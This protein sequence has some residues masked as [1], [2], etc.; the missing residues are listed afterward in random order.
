M[1]ESV[2]PHISLDGMGE[3]HV[4]TNQMTGCRC[5]M[6]HMKIKYAIFLV[7]CVLFIGAVSAED[8]WVAS[9]SSTVTNPV[10]VYVL[11]TDISPDPIP[12]GI[13]GQTM[14]NPLKISEIPP[15]SPNNKVT[16]GI[17]ILTLKAAGKKDATTT[18]NVTSGGTGQL[19]LTLEDAEP[20]TGT[21]K[22]ESSPSNANLK[23]KM[24][25]LPDST[26]FTWG[27][28]HELTLTPGC[29][30]ISLT[31]DGYYPMWNETFVVGGDVN[32]VPMEMT[33]IPTT[34][35]QT[36]STF[37]LNSPEDPSAKLMVN[38]IDKGLTP[39]TLEM[40]PGIYNYTLSKDNYE[41]ASGQFTIVAGVTNPLLN[42]KLNPV[43]PK[44]GVYLDTK[45]ES[46]SISIGC[47]TSSNKTLAL[48]YFSYFA[49]DTGRNKFTVVYS[50]P[51]FKDNSLY[52]DLNGWF[53][54]GGPY[55]AQVV[56]MEPLGIQITTPVN[57]SVLP[58]DG[59]SNIYYNQKK[60]YRFVPEFGYHLTDLSY[61][62]KSQGIS[63][64][65]NQEIQWT[66]P[67]PVIVNHTISATYAINVYNL[68][69]TSTPGGT[70]SPVG[71]Q[72]V[73]NSQS[74]S[75]TYAPIEGYQ[76]STLTVNGTSIDIKKY[77]TSYTFN[78][79]TSDNQKIEVAFGQT[80]Y[81][82]V[83]RKSGQG[84]IVPSDGT[85]YVPA[86]ATQSFSVNPASGWR[87]ARVVVNNEPIANLQN[88][89]MVNNTVTFYSVR[90]NYYMDVAFEPSI[91]YI[92]ASSNT[93]GAIT[94]SGTNLQYPYNS[95]PT[96][97]M[98][99]NSGY[100]LGDVIVNGA[101][102]GITNPYTFNQINSNKT[103][104]A[105]YNQI[106]YNIT[107]TQASNGVI[108]P[109]TQQVAW[110]S[111]P[112]YTFTPSSG[113]VVQNVL[114]S[115]VS[116]GAISSYTFAP[117]TSDQTLT[118][119]FV[120]KAY[121]IS[122]NASAGGSINPSG[123]VSADYGTNKQFQITP[124]TGNI[125]GS[126]V[127]D[128]TYAGKNSTYTFP[129]IVSN[130][131][132]SANF[133][134]PAVANFTANPL[135]GTG[136]LTVQFSDLSLNNPDEKSFIWEFGDGKIVTG[137]KNPIYAY[138]N[139][140]TYT[141]NL[142]C[143]NLAN[144]NTPSRVSKRDYILVT[145]A[146]FPAFIGTP[147]SADSQP[148][149]VSFTDYSSGS[150]YMWAWNFGDGGY[151]FEKNPI[152]TYRQPGFFNVS[153]AVQNN[154]GSNYLI[155]NNYVIVKD[156]PNAAF[157]ASV[158]SGVSPL[159][160]MF[161]DESTSYAP[162]NEWFWSFGDGGYSVEKNP[163]YSYMKPGTYTVSLTVGNVNGRDPS[164]YGRQTVTKTGL[165]KV[166]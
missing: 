74:I 130:H 41:T 116:K 141:V 99:A 22:V 66:T 33:P 150:P 114:V 96:F 54:S 146:P 111:T 113:Y 90:N 132:I 14:S 139:Y 61:D 134:M 13:A 47:W 2:N 126:V 70:I 34:G 159:T 81:P 38:G 50:Q 20:V 55:T 26:F 45:P 163:R 151:S 65:F 7:L 104:Q 40:S 27:T 106:M 21:L 42:V 37:I 91:Y 142:T 98:N 143:A 131:S 95:S 153:L 161:T 136:P 59:D 24:C 119:S 16:A 105:K 166:T 4:T 123:I 36:I 125:I 157:D 64:P 9:S 121:Y 75:F 5:M 145:P 31:M 15:G 60:T 127:V 156:I 6:K 88:V 11:K 62:G 80:P 19:D 137:Q 93:G 48:E 122:A 46:S 17:Y 115:G 117:V 89:T 43:T 8:I 110:G 112:T 124:D 77:P 160:V 147:T 133:M 52:L 12:V 148:L 56:N 63:S 30:N 152:H 83:V 85:V 102:V 57:G 53:P 97:S 49:S 94:P 32:S 118:G 108:S 120:I 92:T 68:T 138:N 1:R 164:I 140:G 165:I 78:N 84:T 69:S 3:V 162:I 23:T 58:N 128:G 87:I 39:Q 72:K 158:T 28:K 109:G 155:K 76:L 101:S 135:G 67:D 100:Y 154:F 44:I 10:T 79:V 29:Y 73:T 103:I 86:G 35:I 25:G 51:N 129:N 82:I 18:V 107:V 149:T 144:G 71:T